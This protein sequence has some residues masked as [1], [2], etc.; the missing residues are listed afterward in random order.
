MKEW[1]DVAKKLEKIVLQCA[2][3]ADLDME[4]FTADVRPADP[5]FGD[6]Q[7]NGALPYAKR[8]KTNPRQ[9]AQG[10]IS[11]LEKQSEITDRFELSIAGPGFINFTFK[12][13]FLLD[14]SLIHI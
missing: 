1:F 5:R 9:V 12:K 3:D 11:Q 10:I 8:Q 7:A 13:D 14:L 4:T 2:S 6:I